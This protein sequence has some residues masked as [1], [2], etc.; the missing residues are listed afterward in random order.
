MNWRFA[1]ASLVA[2]G[3]AFAGQPV[4]VGVFSLFRPQ[5]LVVKPAAAEVLRVEIDGRAVY[6]EGAQSAAFRR[7]SDSV[8]CF[9]R[10]E[11]VTARRARVAARDGGAANFLLSVPGRIERRFRGTLEVASRGGALEAVV[12]LDIE[13][14][15]ASVVAAE[16]PPGAPIEALKAQAVVARSYYLATRGRHAG[17]DFCDTTHCQF[18]REPASDE[19]AARE[20]AGLA[21]LYQREPVA[22]LYSASCGGRTKSLEEIRLPAEGYPYYSVDCAACRREA[23][24]WTARFSG[25]DAQRLRARPQSEAV[26]LEIVRRLGWSALPGNNYQIEPEE[27]A[28]VLR[29][30]GAGHGVGLCQQGAAAMAATGVDFR[31][32]LNRYFPATTIA[33]R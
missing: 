19:S 11:L 3:A 8:D 30:R 23:R 31:V 2:G 10:R 33:V 9:V 14:A 7:V 4:R 5:R 28:V 13:T 18:L 21:L 27:D 6:L 22:A 16:S 26:R 24:E 29:G 15:V 25:P 12:S 20:T 32:I 17:F 1:L